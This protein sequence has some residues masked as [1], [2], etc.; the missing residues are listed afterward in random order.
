M[1]HRGL[2][3]E[4]PETGN[5]IPEREHYKQEV[6]EGRE[7]AELGIRVNS[8]NERHHLWNNNGTWFIHYTVYP[9]PVTARRVR[10]SLK[11]KS[12][13]VA[14]RRRDEILGRQS[15]FGRLKPERWNLQADFIGA[16]I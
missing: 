12:L 7:V 9:T 2:V 3:A 10:R 4:K 15:E 6:R 8:A 11:T 13:A 14:I 16:G 5:L 1:T